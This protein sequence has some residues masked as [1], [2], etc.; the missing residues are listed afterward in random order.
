MA[1]MLLAFSM[2]SSLLVYSSVS[3]SASS[4]TITSLPLGDSHV[5]AKTPAVG[6]EL[7]CDT[8]T[9]DTGG[10]QG[11]SPWITGDTWNPSLKPVVAGSVS[12]S[13]ASYSVNISGSNRVITTNGLPV[14][15][16]TG[17]YPIATSDPAYQYDRNPN[18]IKVQKVLFSVPANPILT[19]T[20][21]CTGRGVIGYMTNGVAIFNAL[22]A[23]NRD[24][25]AHEL[26]D[27]CGGHPQQNGTYH[28]HSGSPC[29]LAGAT[30]P[31]TLVGYAL[32]GF[33]I[34]AERDSGGNLLTNSSLDA[35]HGRTSTVSWDGKDVSMYHYDITNEFPYIIG[36]F[37]GS[38]SSSVNGSG[39]N[40]SVG[41]ASGGKCDTLQ[42]SSPSPVATPDSSS[43]P[44]PSTSSQPS[45]PP[46]VGQG[47]DKPGPSEGNG[48][49]MPPVCNIINPEPPIMASPPVVVNPPL[50]TPQSSQNASDRQ[51]GKPTPRLTVKPS[52]K[53][54]SKGKSTVNPRLPGKQDSNQNKP[55]SKPMPQSSEKAMPQPSG[56][57]SI[58][59]GQGNKG[60]TENQ[61][62][63]AHNPGEQGSSGVIPAP[64]AGDGMPVGG[65]GQ[66]GGQGEPSC[67]V[68][69]IGVPFAPPVPP[70][71]SAAVPSPMPTQGSG[72][73]GGDG[74]TDK[75]CPPPPPPGQNPP[76]SQ[77]RL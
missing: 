55:S 37:M 14:G 31:S 73:S 58:N 19:S 13:E 66:P 35:C 41:N 48:C 18:S 28:Y 10:A 23:Q 46:Q 53:G 64:S 69:P 36:C 22:D 67:L 32:D 4:S 60:N 9:N 15:S 74:Q 59:S 8:T 77:P 21:G 2:I 57:P 40:V 61:C 62:P 71:L 75:N 11:A 24:A 56:R 16:T 27:S 12:W 47:G 6:S 43:I 44:M 3:S 1:K 52:S 76:T 54:K 65:N 63:P 51:N 26:Q 30:G 70:R 34:Y 29:I 25:A 5:T 7:V 17:V 39:G 45:M 33:G 68:N 42:T 72:K 50:P 49:V 20:P 38:T